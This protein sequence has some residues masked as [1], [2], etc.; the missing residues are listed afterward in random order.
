MTNKGQE[1]EGK[2]FIPHWSA[3]SCKKGEVEDDWQ[4]EPQ[5]E[6]HSDTVLVKATCHSQAKVSHQ[7]YSSPCKNGLLLLLMPH[8]VNIQEQTVGSR[9]LV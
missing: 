6:V 7:N 1:K 9:V 2:A 4:E 5:S 8:S 3:D